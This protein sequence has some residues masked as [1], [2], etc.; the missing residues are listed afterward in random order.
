[1]EFTVRRATKTLVILRGRETVE[2]K[3]R[4]TPERVRVVQSASPLPVT[5]GI[6]TV[7][8]GGNF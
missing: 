3:I 6:S 1:M 5:G 2:V 7:I 4:N 8:D